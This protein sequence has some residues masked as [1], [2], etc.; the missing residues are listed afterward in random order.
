VPPGMS[1]T[2]AIE[3]SIATLRTSFPALFTE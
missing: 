1:P 3:P 2:Q